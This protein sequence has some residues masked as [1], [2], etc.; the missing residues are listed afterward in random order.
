MAKIYEICKNVFSIAEVNNNRKFN[1]EDIDTFTLIFEKGPFEIQKECKRIYYIPKYDRIFTKQQ[2]ID[3]LN[4]HAD[5]NFIVADDYDGRINKIFFFINSQMNL[6]TVD[7][8]HAYGEHNPTLVKFATFH[9]IPGQ[10]EWDKAKLIGKTVEKVE[11]VNPGRSSYYRDEPDYGIYFTFPGYSSAIYDGEII[12]GDKSGSTYQIA[13]LLKDFLRISG[14]TRIVRDE[15]SYS[16]FF[17]Y[18]TG[19]DPIKE[20]LPIHQRY[21]LPLSKMVAG[22]GGRWG[23][24]NYRYGGEFMLSQGETLDAP[25]PEEDYK[26]IKERIELKLKQMT[27]DKDPYAMAT[28]DILLITD[29]IKGHRRP[30]FHL[31]RGFR[32]NGITEIVELSRGEMLIKD[33]MPEKV[34]CLTDM[35]NYCLASYNIKSQMIQMIK[36]DKVEIDPVSFNKWAEEKSLHPYLLKLLST[37]F[38]DTIDLDTVKTFNKVPFGSLLIEQLITTNHGALAEDLAEYITEKAYDFNFFCGQLSDIF[39]GCN[40]EETSLYKILNLSRNSAK[41]LFEEEDNLNRFITKYEALRYYNGNLVLTEDIKRKVDNYLALQTQGLHK[42]TLLWGNRT[43]DFLKYPELAKQVI[44][45]LKKIETV[46][47][48]QNIE[49]YRKRDIQNKYTEIVRAYCSFLDY[50]EIAPENEKDMWHPERL[51]IFL[52]FSLTGTPENP[53]NPYEEISSRETAA[54]T[55]LKIYEQKAN[56]KMH[57][58]NETKFAYRRHQMLKLRSYATLEKENKDFQGFVVI[59][60]TQVYGVSAVGSV[61][62]EANDLHH[63]LFRCYT[64]RIVEG[65]YTTMWLRL[66]DAVNESVITIGIT[67]DGRIEQT[68]GLHD[69]DA[70]PEEAR[71]IAAWAASKKGMV[72]FKSEGVDVM[73]GGWP[74]GVAVPSLPKP[75]KD[76]LLQLRQTHEVKY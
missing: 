59:P 43:F 45:M 65:E 70:T 44:R 74:R 42:F 20:S 15:S 53:L 50:R 26:R 48:E 10:A 39:P 9:N 52:E 31:V 29:P 64:Q 11:Y 2:A 25:I 17:K 27:H 28:T 8:F 34:Y 72:T 58:E 68:R 51:M 54:N 4:E 22:Q 30:T 75:E 21:G 18:A 37:S 46:S 36:S 76:W 40:G 61:E 63:C 62:K 60:P 69:R 1:L 32:C 19:I 14:R 23:L 12:N 49:Y 55:A 57:E 16:S 66:K 56:E 35:N 5:E 13:N 7:C 71:A 73:P 41:Y 47:Q 6:L 38:F 3:F 67:E 33:M 24:Y